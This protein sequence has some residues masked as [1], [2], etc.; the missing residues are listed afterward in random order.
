MP[1]L[2]ALALS[3]AAPDAVPVTSSESN[4][5]SFMGWCLKI[6]ELPPGADPQA[7]L[8][9]RNRLPGELSPGLVAVRAL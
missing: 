7:W 8:Q 4:L 9:C 3:S 6:D 1:K 2:G 5:E